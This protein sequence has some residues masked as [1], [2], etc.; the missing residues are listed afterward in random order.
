MKYFEQIVQDT[1]D[2]TLSEY[3]SVGL[4]KSGLL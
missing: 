1:T 2:I 3:R 4:V